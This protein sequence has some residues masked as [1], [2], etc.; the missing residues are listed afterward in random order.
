MITAVIVDDEKKNRESLRKLLREYCPDVKVMGES[1][2]VQEA[3]EC[4]RREN[5][6]LVFLDVEMPNGSGFDFLRQMEPVNFKVIFVTAHAHYAIK[7]IRFSALDYLLKPVDTDDLIEAV[8]KTIEKP[9][10][11]QTMQYKTLLDNLSATG[12]TKL[13]I[14]I[15]DGFAFLEPEEII[16]LEADGTYTHLYTIDQKY[17]G[18]KNIKEYEQMLQDHFFFRS[19]HSHL[20]NLHHVKKFS[21]LDGYFVQMSDGSEVEI[22][23]RKK[24]NFLEVISRSGSKP[25]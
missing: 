10:H 5:P 24:D 15:K 18:T 20:I 9:M 22:S 4:C 1:A 8:R 12:L 11:A 23:R 17:T 13:A 2:S 25:S 6:D 14:P 7:A 3:I 21:R 16:R 19:H